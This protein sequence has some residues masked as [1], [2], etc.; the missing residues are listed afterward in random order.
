[1][2]KTTAVWEDKAIGTTPPLKLRIAIP[3]YNNA[4][5]V[6]RVVQD[7]L[8]TGAEVMV[9]D[10]GSTDGTADR[11]DALPVHIIRHD[12]N[13][14]KGAAILSALHAC[15]EKGVTHMVTLDA[16]GQHDPRD[17]PRFIAAIKSNPH[18]FLVG[19][20]NFNRMTTPWVSRFGRRFS[21]FWFRLQTGRSLQDTQC[22]FRAYPVVALDR[23]RLRE[24]H[25]SFEIEVLVKAAWAGVPLQDVTVSVFYPEK[26]ERVSHFHPFTDNLRL[27][28]LNT[29]LTLRSMVPW[30]HRQIHSA[31]PR[32]SLRQPVKSLRRL[33]KQNLSPEALAL[34]AFLG[35]FL[36]TLPILGFHTIAILFTAGYFR[37]SK[38]MAV[39]SSQLCMPP[40]VPALCIEIGYYLRHGE[41]LTEISIKTIGHQGL[42]RIME[43]LLGSLVL[44][45]AI[46]FVAGFTVYIRLRQWRQAHPALRRGESERPLWE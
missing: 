46:G 41:F 38:V 19:N 34:S 43:W 11:L 3:A 24:R 8:E 31:G 30:P 27:T 1:M 15:R 25:F 40:F 13:M 14:G 42:E 16:D 10:D 28:L 2:R 12:R 22:G 6:K 32:V 21:N 29:R 17:V 9:V 44:A 45:P 5:T 35:V 37:L 4:G 33:L 36:G 20:R 18:A 39:A 23:L 7:A 26:S